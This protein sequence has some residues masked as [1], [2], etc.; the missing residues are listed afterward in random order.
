VLFYMGKLGFRVS[1]IPLNVHPAPLAK[2]FARRWPPTL[3]HLSLK[4]VTRP[5][6]TLLL[7]KPCNRWVIV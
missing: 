1:S 7:Q 4:E 2:M 3:V 6:S 5:Q